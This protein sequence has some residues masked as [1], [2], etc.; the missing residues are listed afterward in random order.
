MKKSFIAAVFALTFVFCSCT[1][2]SNGAGETTEISSEVQSLSETSLTDEKPVSERFK[3]TVNEYGIYITGYIGGQTVVT[4]P[5]EIDGTNVYKVSDNAFR[6]SR[7]EELIIPEGMTQVKCIKGANHLKKLV[8]PSTADKI[9]T[10]ELAYL[11]ELNDIEVA[12]GGNFI[13]SNGAL[14]SA[15]GKTLFPRVRKRSAS[16][17]FRTKSSARSAS[18]QRLKLSGRGHLRTVKTCLKQKYRQA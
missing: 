15:D 5:T 11:P 12:E 6:G 17:H 4:I 13:A 7:V 3:Y 9:D 16:L 8:L 1:N 14:F 18:R 2:R 10:L